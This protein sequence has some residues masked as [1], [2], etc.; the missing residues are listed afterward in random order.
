MKP[1]ASVTSSVVQAFSTPDAST[2]NQDST[3]GLLIA[4]IFALILL[5]LAIAVI[6]GYVFLI[7]ILEE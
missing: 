6:I 3:I 1:S 2:R 5:V 4:F 7:M